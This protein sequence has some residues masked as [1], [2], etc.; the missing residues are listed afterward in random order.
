MARL[1]PN[2]PKRMLS[3]NKAG[4]ENTCQ[5]YQSKQLQHWYLT[6][7]FYKA[8]NLYR[9]YYKL[10]RNDIN[11]HIWQQRIY[12]M[13]VKPTFRAKETFL[14]N[15]LQPIG[16]CWP[17]ILFHCKVLKMLQSPLWPVVVLLGQAVCLTWHR[18]AGW[19]LQ[20]EEQSGEE[21]I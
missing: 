17:V 16:G 8:N 7:S 12:C 13:Y 18:Y 21:K 11:R 2:R 20:Q 1:A 4:W 19:G 6:M 3:A 9:N 5:K 14:Y 10:N 15:S